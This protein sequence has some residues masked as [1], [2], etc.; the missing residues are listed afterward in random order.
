[1]TNKA[2]AN[3]AIHP[4]TNI[5]L[6]HHANSVHNTTIKMAVVSMAKEDITKVS[7]VQ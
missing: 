2:I 3:E 1:M 5:H 7:R 4:A 6:L